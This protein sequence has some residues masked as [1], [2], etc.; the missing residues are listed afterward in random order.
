MNNSGI[1]IKSC[2]QPKYMWYGKIPY[3]RVVVVVV[4][5]VATVTMMCTGIEIQCST[6]NTTLFNGG[7][8]INGCHIVLCQVDGNL[9]RSFWIEP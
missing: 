7:W 5:V 4:A 2:R 1:R 6:N 9:M 3:L 8:M